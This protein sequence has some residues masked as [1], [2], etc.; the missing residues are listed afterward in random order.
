MPQVTIGSS[1]FKK[2]RQEYADWLWAMARESSQNCLDAPGSTRM[3]VTITNVGCNT[4]IVFENDGQ[5][6]TE[7]VLVGKLLAIG[8]SGK[9]FEGSVGGFGKAKTLLYMMNESYVIRTGTLEVTGNGGQYELATDLPYFHGTRSSV[10]IE[11]DVVDQ[12]RSAFIRFAYYTQWSGSFYLNGDRLD[13]NMR[14]GSPRRDLGFG[15]VY[16]NKSAKHRMVVRIC[17][18]PMFIEYCDPDRCVIVELNGASHE[19]LTSN[20]DSLKHPHSGELSRFVTELAVD[21]KSALKPKYR[22]PT[23]TIY[24]GDRLEHTKNET[25]KSSSIAALVGNSED[26]APVHSE[27]ETNDRVVVDP[28]AGEIETQEPS[29]DWHQQPSYAP[30]YQH[31]VQATTRKATVGVTGYFVVKNDTDL[32]IPDYYMPHREE[33]SDYSK[34]LARIWARLMFSLHTM[35]E[36]EGDFGVGFIFSDTDEAQFEQTNEY[37]KIYYVNPAVIVG[38]ESSNSRSFKKAYKLNER[39]RLIATAAHEFVHGMGYSIHDEEYSSKFTDIMGH[40]L[41]HAS[42]FAWCFKR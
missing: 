35:F 6:M 21:K 5:P 22:G 15:V 27:L 40:V 24:D 42:K 29:S 13:S 14:K 7:E 32:K 4:L 11:G 19:V 33:F 30:S 1:F 38:Q 41:T 8:E 25:A 28:D 23:Y 9:N 26:W 36:V 20:R 16:T 37:G 39:G 12:L 2:E 3:D 18:I 10:V 34:K 31:E 17:G